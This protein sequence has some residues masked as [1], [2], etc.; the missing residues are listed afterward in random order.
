MSKE[1]LTELEN[2]SAAI[3]K[4]IAEAERTIRINQSEAAYQKKRLKLVNDQIEYLK[5]TYADQPEEK[6]VGEEQ[7]P[8]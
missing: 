3:V 6:T 1:R 4:A 7:K 8:G 5:E 2:E